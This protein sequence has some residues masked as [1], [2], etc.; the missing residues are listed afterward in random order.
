M[1][2]VRFFYFD[3]SD[4]SAVADLKDTTVNKIYNSLVGQVNAGE[5]CAPISAFHI[6]E[7]SHLDPAYRDAGLR[8]A[9]VLKKLSCGLAYPYPT[10]LWIAE[11]TT[12][13]KKEG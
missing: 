10:D 7:C 6:S 13:L 5:V 4:I 1:A 12:L 3:S 9:K 11:W 8:R 2:P